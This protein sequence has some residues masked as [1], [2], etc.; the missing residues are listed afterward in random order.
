MLRFILKSPIPG[1]M[2]HNI[3]RGI[4]CLLHS[5]SSDSAYKCVIVVVCMKCVSTC[6]CG[7]LFSARARHPE[8]GL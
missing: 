3:G 7:D 4:V 1:K 2:M 6:H 8:A 5:V